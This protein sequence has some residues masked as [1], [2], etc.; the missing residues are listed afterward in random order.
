VEGAQRSPDLVGGIRPRGPIEAA[1]HGAKVELVCQPLADPFD[2]LDCGGPGSALGNWVKGVKAQVGKL[3]PKE[4]G[5]PLRFVIVCACRRPGEHCDLHSWEARAPAK[6]QAAHQ[7]DC[8]GE[9]SGHRENGKSG[10]KQSDEV[11]EQ[12]DLGDLF[13]VN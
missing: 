11:S 7:P 13:N 4:G 6:A 8:D 12:A 1:E 9:Y 2:D 5:D 3:L 10:G